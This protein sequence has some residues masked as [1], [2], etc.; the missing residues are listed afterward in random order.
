M[1]NIYAGN[2]AY[3]VTE[4]DLRQAFSAY[5]TVER[6]SVIMDRLTGRSRGFGFVEMADE[7]EARAAIEGLHEADLK[8]RKMLIR[9]ARPKGEHM[10]TTARRER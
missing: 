6:A 4:E 9:E 1:L 5:G 3:T 2:L 8:G 7:A 10:A